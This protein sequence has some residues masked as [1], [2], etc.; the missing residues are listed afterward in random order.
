[1]PLIFVRTYEE[2]KSHF[3]IEFLIDHF[4]KDTLEMFTSSL[5]NIYHTL[6]I[7]NKYSESHILFSFL[8]DI[9]TNFE[10]LP[11]ES[12]FIEQTII[13]AFNVY[14]L[15]DGNFISLH[16]L[17]SKD[18]DSK[19]IDGYYVTKLWNGNP[20]NHEKNNNLIEAEWKIK[21]K[22]GNEIN[23][24]SN[25]ETEHLVLNAIKDNQKDAW[26]EMM[27]KAKTD[28][29]VIKDNAGNYIFQTI[30]NSQ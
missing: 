28:V 19:P 23:S 20:D 6:I 26:D 21:K 3:D 16:S 13:G 30:N 24:F 22:E 8:C 14:L 4:Y 10:L 17:N 25:A 5:R 15:D 7:E 27:E 9:K 2:I 29:K 12:L 11:T 1:M 18:S